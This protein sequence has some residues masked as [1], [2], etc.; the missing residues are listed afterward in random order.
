MMSQ[1]NDNNN[2]FGVVWG[3]GCAMLR[4]VRRHL[5]PMAREIMTKLTTLRLILSSLFMLL[6]LC[7][8]KS[9]R[10]CM[11]LRLRSLC[12]LIVGTF[13]VSC[14][15]WPAVAKRVPSQ[16]FGTDWEIIPSATT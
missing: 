7:L 13:E 15:K 2:D 1:K 11:L 3:V 10:N 6:C 8:A 14:S 9:L 4:L 5:Q 16:H 12:I